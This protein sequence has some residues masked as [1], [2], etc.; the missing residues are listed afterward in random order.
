M[1]VVNHGRAFS[2]GVLTYSVECACLSII[3]LFWCQRQI[4][5]LTAPFG[6]LTR[7]ALERTN[8]AWYQPWNPGQLVTEEEM[9]RER[10][11][12]GG[13][14]S[15]PK[16]SAWDKGKRGYPRALDGPQK[17]PTNFTF[18]PTSSLKKDRY[19]SVHLHF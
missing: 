9:C 15:F 18:K 8:L 16:W 4:G 3:A 13:E 5:S 12:E 17:F 2:F 19:K 1:E 11:E 10:P 6:R 14:E 7:F